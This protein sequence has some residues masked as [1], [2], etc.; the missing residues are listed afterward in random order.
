MLG[1]EP[2]GQIPSLS[3]NGNVL[4]SS[5]HILLPHWHSLSICRMGLTFTGAFKNPV[6]FYIHKL[7]SVL[8]SMEMLP[9]ES[10]SISLE[11]RP[12]KPVPY[13]HPMK[14]TLGSANSR[15]AVHMYDGAMQGKHT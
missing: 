6:G 12:S 8:A 11:E 9:T 10:P 15:D 2:R 7:P 14:E 13:E 4:V 5:R 1:T 3:H